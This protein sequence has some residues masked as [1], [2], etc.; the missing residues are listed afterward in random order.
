MPNHQAPHA[1]S[2]G[3]SQFFQRLQKIA[4][5]DTG[6]TSLA[7]LCTATQ[8]LLENADKISEQIVLHLPQFTLHDQTHLWN[9]LSFMEELA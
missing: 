7:N 8:R 2:F 9:V 1:D 5:G 6:N 3:K 4:Q